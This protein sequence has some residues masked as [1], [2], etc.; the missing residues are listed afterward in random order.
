MSM[1]LEEASTLGRRTAELHLAL[2]GATE[3]PAFIPETM[4]PVDLQV[5]SA[6]MKDHAEKT[7][8]ELEQNLPGL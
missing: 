2:A 8:E 4:T 3:D 1:D 5:L 6:A 7:M